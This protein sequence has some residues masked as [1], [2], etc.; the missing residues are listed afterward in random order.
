MRLLA[1]LVLAPLLAAAT[2]PSS[3]DLGTKEGLCRPD[4][5]GP[6]FLV[7]VDG[8]KDRRGHLKL[9]VYPANDKDFLADDNVLISAGKTFRRREVAVPD[10]GPVELCIRL[11]SAGTY[12][13]TLLHD[14][15]SNRKFGWRV[16]GIGFA[17]NP[18]LGWDK[19]PANAASVR[20]GSTPTRIGIVLNYWRGLS[21]RPIRKE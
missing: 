5:K 3:P 2:I 18:K 12:A 11:P 9:E 8:L 20:A 10:K 15:D 19:P 13:V 16:D 7:S 4:E 6:A 1:S 17:S 14:R 21:M